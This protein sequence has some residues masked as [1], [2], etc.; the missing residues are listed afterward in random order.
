MELKDL[1]ARLDRQAEA[2]RDLRKR[3]AALEGA[4]VSEPPDTWEPPIGC[5]MCGGDKERID[6]L[7]CNACAEKRTEALKAGGDRSS[8]MNDTCAACGEEFGRNIRILCRDCGQRWKVW[9]RGVSRN[10]GQAGAK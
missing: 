4:P 1:L 5:T 7:T 6:L 9:K 8:V 10:G 3:V 2:I